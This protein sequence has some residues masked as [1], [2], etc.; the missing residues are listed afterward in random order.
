[1]RVRLHVRTLLARRTAL[2]ASLPAPIDSVGFVCHIKGKPSHKV[3]AAVEIG[4]LSCPAP[5]NPA[6]RPLA[7]IVS[8][9]K[10]LLCMYTLARCPS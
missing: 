7:Q 9:A 6:L 10:H 8:D 1:M 5:A 4:S 2:T 3:S